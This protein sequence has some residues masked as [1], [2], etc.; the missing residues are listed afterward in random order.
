MIILK[1]T[2]EQRELLLDALT[3]FANN[4]SFPDEAALREVTDLEFLVI[5]AAED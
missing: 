3:F 2:D 1:L 4:Q 5:D